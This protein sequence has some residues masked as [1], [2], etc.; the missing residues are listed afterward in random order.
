MKEQEQKKS[1]NQEVKPQQNQDK[2]KTQNPKNKVII[3]SSIGAAAATLS[4]IVSF[5]TIFSNQRKV[6]FLD[7]VLQSIKIDVKDKETK[8]KEDIKTIADFVASG[9]NNK[10]YELIVETEE[11]QV[12]KQPLDKD[13]PYTTFRTK[14]AIRNK[15]TKAQSNYR[16]FEFKDIKPPKEKAELNELGKERVVVK[17]FD[18]F[19]R[20]LNVASKTLE[21]ENGKYKHFEVF[22]KDNNSDDLKYEIVNIKAIADD[23]KSEAIISYQ[24]KVKSINDEKFTS[25]VLEVKFDDFAKNSE[26]LTEYLNTVEFSYENADATYIQEAIETKVIGKKDGINLPSHYALIFDEFTK[27]GE[28]PKKITAKVRLKDN[29]NNFI[30]DQKDIE[31]TGFKKYLT[32]EELNGYIDT[33]Q[34]DVENKQTQE[35]SNITSYSQLSK[36]NFD[37]NKYE[38]D[39]NTFVIEKL[40][41]LVSLN[42]HFRIKEKDGKPGIYSKQKTLKIRDFKMP[43]KLVNDLAQQVSFDVTDKSNKMAY[44]FWDK[45]DQSAYEITKDPRININIKEV[46]QSNGDSISIKYIVNDTNGTTSTEVT[47]VISGF[48]NSDQNESKY[49]YEIIEYKG[50]KAAY[51]NGRKDLNNFV[52]PANIGNYKVIKVGTLFTNVLRTSERVIYGVVLQEGIVEVNNLVVNTEDHKYAQIAAISLPK[53]IKKITNLISGVSSHFAN[54]KMYDNVEEIN[55]LF[56]EY[57]NNI[58]VGELYQ[59]KLL[60]DTEHTSTFW[61]ETRNYFEEFFNI[62]TADSGRRGYGSFKLQLQESGENKKLKTN[63]YKTNYTFLE[64]QDGKTLYKVF[65]NKEA[66]LA[67]FDSRLEYEI[68]A[69]SAFSYL[70]VKEF[71]FWAPKLNMQK[72]NWFL[73]EKLPSLKKIEFKDI[74]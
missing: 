48:K 8:T 1:N 10:L 67:K 14:F 61:F 63:S 19:R 53:T 69:K 36:T 55:G 2:V 27:E 23:K 56:N 43:E 49:S 40:D 26:Q 73:F 38:V 74:S 41:D 13:K 72:F 71:E 65:T 58:G 50:N 33:V 52:V 34:F 6:S 35:I 17:F 54:L 45:V 12:N 29:V 28:H 57:E 25:D 20:E 30:S 7:K 59:L 70:G 16:T 31:I 39:P 21:E 47:K 24:L 4:S 60:G 37:D 68:I 42:I 18:E 22:L 64:S 51:L 11:D 46:K 44:E 66:D 15:F 9:L 32:P 5:S 62:K 3:W